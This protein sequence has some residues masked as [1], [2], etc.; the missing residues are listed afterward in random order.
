MKANVLSVLFSVIAVA[1]VIWQSRTPQDMKNHAEY[2]GSGKNLYGANSVGQL[3]RILRSNNSNIFQEY[4]GLQGEVNTDVMESMTNIPGLGTTLNVQIVQEEEE[5]SQEQLDELIHKITNTWN[6]TFINMVEDYI[7]FTERNNI[8]DGEWKCQMWNQ[9]WYKYLQFLAGSLNE[10]IENDSYPLEMKEYISD[11]FLYWAN[12]D[13]IWFLSI[14][15]AEWDRR[16][17]LPEQ[18]AL[19]A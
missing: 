6:D 19:Q 3:G 8:I 4:A 18:P 14:V 1:S 10:V 9:R 15:R 5:Q 11:E 12:H 7:D 2:S 13:F 17:E 16:V